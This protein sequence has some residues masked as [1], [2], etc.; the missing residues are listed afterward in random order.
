MK[1]LSRSFFECI[2]VGSENCPCYLAETGDCMTC[3]RLAGLDYCDCKWQGVCIYNEYM[4]NHQKAKNPREEI[5]TK[6]VDKKILKGNIAVLILQSNKYLCQRFKYPGTFIFARNPMYKQIYDIPLSIMYVDSEKD[7]IHIAVKII[8][9]KTKALIES[10][11]ELL[12]KGPYRNGIIGLKSLQNGDKGKI[13]V[14]CRN[15]GLAPAIKLADYYKNR[16]NIDVIADNFRLEEDFSKDYFEKLNILPINKNFK[17]EKDLNDIKVLAKEGN[18]D[19]VVIFTSN[20]YIA[21]FEELLEDKND[22][23]VLN[24]SNMCCGEGICGSCSYVNDDGEVIKMCKCQMK[25]KD[26]KKGGL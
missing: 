16:K 3:S 18:Y 6:I 5:A 8:S 9:A 10:S 25:A 22:Y 12:I 24:N 23:A 13:L 14:I 19:S 21:I 20:K 4:W 2:D 11:D 15:M 17:N 7:Q 1:G 26:K